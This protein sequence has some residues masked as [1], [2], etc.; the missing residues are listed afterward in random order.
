MNKY[1]IS[2]YYT[3]N[4][5]RTSLRTKNKSKEKE[6]AKK[7]NKISANQA[8]I[9]LV[10]FDLDIRYGPCRFITRTKRYENAEKLGLEPGREIYNLIKSYDLE[11]SFYDKKCNN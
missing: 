8:E 11:K 1:S 9:K 5:K 7:K 6:V 3:K 4:K 10:Q 2:D